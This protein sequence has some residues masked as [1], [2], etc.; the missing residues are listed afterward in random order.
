[1]PLAW[2]SV[3]WHEQQEYIHCILFRVGIST[4]LTMSYQFYKKG[5]GVQPRK[6]A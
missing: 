5:E 2:H 1:M 6:L 4:V 3:F